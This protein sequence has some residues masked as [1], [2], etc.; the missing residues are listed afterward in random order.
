MNLDFGYGS[1]ASRSLFSPSS[2]PHVGV[3]LRR[4][5]R[6]KPRQ[7]GLHAGLATILIR[8]RPSGPHGS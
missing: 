8:L 2:V 3:S 4:G 5:R 1:G 6:R 7:C